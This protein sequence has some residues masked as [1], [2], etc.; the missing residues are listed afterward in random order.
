MSVHF[1]AKEVS[2]SAATVVFGLWG[3]LGVATPAT[4]QV[5]TAVEYGFVTPWDYGYSTFFVT[6]FP[7]E[8]AALDAG[9]FDEQCCG[10]WQ[11]TGA[12]FNVWSGPES[13]ALPTCRFFNATSFPGDHFYTPYAAECAAVQAHADWHYQYEGIVFY[14][15]VPDE[16]GNCPVGTTILY[17]LYFGGGGAPLHIFTTSLAGFQ[18][19]ANGW[20]LEGDA[21]TGAFACVPSSTT[22]SMP[23]MLL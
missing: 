9:A 10:S 1:F 20:V 5:E 18:T 22:P 12:T 13:G 17:R 8:I 4:A 19:S 14:L 7:D 11:R 2:A 16:N 6:W 3:L 21:R 15:K 23:K